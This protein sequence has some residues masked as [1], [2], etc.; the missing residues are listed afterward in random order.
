ME[1]SN[2]RSSV[3]RLFALALKVK[4]T[5]TFVG[6]APPR[7]P[8]T[9]NGVMFP[10]ANEDVGARRIA[11]ISS[12]IPSTFDANQPNVILLHIGTNDLSS[13]A[14][15]M[16]S[17]LGALLDKILRAR[18]SARLVVARIIQ[19]SHEQQLDHRRL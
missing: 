8:L 19:P 18:P 13:G 10:R 12:L 6:S 2:V 4:Q 3:T 7:G 9:V 11:D 15:S 16:A 17:Q 5:M 1:G 14:S